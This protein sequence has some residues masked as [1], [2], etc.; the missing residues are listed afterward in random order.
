MAAGLYISIDVISGLSW[1]CIVTVI[2]RYNS[3]ALPHF[4]KHSEN[5]HDF[6]T[7]GRD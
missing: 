5:H 6:S 2:N 7:N 3:A 1:F 4:I